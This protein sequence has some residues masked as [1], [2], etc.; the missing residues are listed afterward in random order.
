[1]KLSVIFAVALSGMAM[2]IALPDEG[3]VDPGGCI[4][5]NCCDHFGNKHLECLG[6]TQPCKT[7]CDCSSGPCKI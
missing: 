7:G 3:Q 4:A 1:M 2:A 6:P 5:T